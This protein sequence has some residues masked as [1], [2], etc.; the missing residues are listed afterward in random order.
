LVVECKATSI[1]D[2]YVLLL[3]LLLVPCLAVL[4]GSG[5]YRHMFMTNGS[6]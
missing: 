5:S 4:A 2:E 1:S 3:L 6:S